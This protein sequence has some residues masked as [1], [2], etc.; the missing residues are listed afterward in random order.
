MKVGEVLTQ[1]RAMKPNQ[2]E[3]AVLLRWLGEVEARLHEEI[4]CRY[5]EPGEPPP[6]ITPEDME[7]ELRVPFPHDGI[8]VKWLAARIDYQNAEFDRYNNAM[9]AFNSDWQAYADWYNRTNMPKQENF[10]GKF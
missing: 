9:V 4:W 8:Y 2:Y 10:I 3:E 6:P 7:R 5:D 1:I